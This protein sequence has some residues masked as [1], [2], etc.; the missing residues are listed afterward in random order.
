[1]YTPADGIYPLGQIN[2]QATGADMRLYHLTENKDY[3][4]AKRVFKTLSHQAQQALGSWEWANWD[5]GDLSQSFERNDAIAQ[6]IETAFAPIRDDMRRRYGDT[7]TLYRGISPSERPV[8][9]DRQLFS[10]TSS[11]DIARH[12]AGEDRRFDNVKPIPDEAVHQALANFK[13][14][15]FVTFRNKK[16]MLNKRNPKYYEIYNRHGQSITD[17]DN[18][19]RE[20][21]DEQRAYNDILKKK[22]AG[23][24]VSH[25]IPIDDIVW[26]LMGGNANEY[27]V[28][29]FAE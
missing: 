23:R 16:Y 27:I 29:G 7:I 20:L 10:W 17:G 28:R 5:N 3:A 8:R 22:S 14:R 6:E 12:F 13:R 15:G 18:L 19:E 25:A 26:V 24:V 9:S 11:R 4:L 1:V 2:T 21:W